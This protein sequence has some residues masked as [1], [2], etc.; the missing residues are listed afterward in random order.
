MS[1]SRQKKSLATQ[2]SVAN[3]LQI[4]NSRALTL[5]LLSG[6]TLTNALMGCSFFQKKQH[7]NQTPTNNT[8]EEFKG[9]IT[10]SSGLPKL[11]PD[12]PSVVYPGGNITPVRVI[13][14]RI[15]IQIQGALTDAQFVATQRESALLSEGEKLKDA[16]LNS[17][18]QQA[19][20]RI[21]D[22]ITIL[23]S[24]ISASVGYFTAWVPY[25]NYAQLQQVTKVPQMLVEPVVVD[26][27]SIQ[28]V[29]DISKSLNDEKLSTDGRGSMDDFSGLRSMGVPEF[30]KQVE[31]E[32]GVKV[33][34]STVK[35]GVGDTGISFNHPAFADEKGNS[36]IIYM[37]DFTGEGT[38]YF[39]RTAAFE[40]KTPTA[41]EVPEGITADEVLILNAEYLETPAGSG[42]RPIADK[43]SK[44]EKTPILVSAQLK[45]ILLTPENGARLGVYNEAL[46]SKKSADEFNDINANGK[47]DDLL[48]AIYVPEKD[49]TKGKIYLDVSGKGDFRKSNAVG[50]WNTT[51]ELVT[52]FSEKFGYDLKATFLLNSANEQVVAMSASVVGFDHGNHGTHVAGIV[53]ARKTLSNDE[54]STL[55]RGA[56][57]NTQIM[58]SRICAVQ[59]GCSATAAA[60]DFAKNGAEVV[61]FSIGGL[62]PEN[63]G[64][65]VGDIITSRLTD[66]Y[67]TLFVIS[68]G[69]SGPGR[70]TIGSPST[71]HKAI[72]VGATANRSMITRQY[73]W[74]GAG[75]SDKNS[76]IEEDFMLFF[77]SRGP[78]ASG[79]FKPNISAPGTELSSIQLNAPAGSRQGLDV[80]WGTS[81]A[82]PAATGAI[83]LL[84]DAAKKYNVIHPTTP[85]PT[86][87]E[88]LRRVVIA[89]ARPFD[90]QSYNTITGEK[91][92]GQYTW[93][94]Q[95]AGMI[96]LPRSW[97]LL[98]D[99][100]SNP[101][102]TSFTVAAAEGNIAVKPEYKVQILRKNPN[103]LDYTGAV[104][105]ELPIGVN[106]NGTK[107][108]VQK[109][110]NGLWLDANTK[111]SL[112]EVH[113]SRSLPESLKSRADVGE[114]MRFL[115]TS[116]DTFELETV[117]HGSKMEWLK[118]GSL[119]TLDCNK[120]SVSPKLTVI[121][122]GG[123][124]TGGGS[125]GF[126]ASNLH[127]CL[128]QSLMAALP[129]GDHGAVINA[130]RVSGGKRETTPSFVV[131]VTMAVPHK[132]LTGLNRYQVQREVKSF[133]VDRNY[134]NIPE[135]TSLV[136]IAL[137]V[138]AT[139]VVGNAVS[140][141]SGAELMILEGQNTAIPAEMS[142]RSKA[143]A[144]NCD[145]K[146]NPIDARR[147]SYE[148]VNPR[149]G[150]WDVHVFGRYQYANSPYTLTVDFAQIMSSLT[151][152]QGDKTALNGEFDITVKE[153]TFKI[154]TSAEKSKYEL[155]GLRQ[156]VTATTEQDKETR[157]ANAAGVVG[158][159]YAAG[160]AAVT[161]STAGATGSDIDLSVLECTE[162][163]LTK[164]DLVGSS[165]GSTD[166]E[167]AQF[168]PKADKFYVG[169]VA[170]YA[171]KGGKSEFKFT[172][173][174]HTEKSDVGT[175]VTT[176]VDETK[177]HVVYSLDADKSTLISSDLFKSGSYDAVGQITM[178]SAEDSQLSVIP[179]VI[180]SKV[181][182]PTPAQ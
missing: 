96:N 88:T 124:T 51:K 77:S 8:Q 61:N 130:Y 83:T 42:A 121:G 176:S 136:R 48:W 65:A 139:S 167:S 85:L 67:N 159:Q 174:I 126:M 97:K 35:M 81:M 144:K 108:I 160:T 99:M 11:T 52:S 26:V 152:I 44:V 72:S 150:T 40:V 5:T 109:F 46:F 15:F 154:S 115:N 91:R 102:N 24:E 128:N 141:C 98:K 180:T 4:G 134:L 39:N 73:Q 13:Q 168:V 133:G 49:G 110:G 38:M 151:S 153:S 10:V 179:V 45:N 101:V 157:V 80:Y 106:A 36:R 69:N 18:I 171:V 19:I 147:V 29:K 94:D 21:S 82:A 87:A 146:G 75:K 25:E 142:P 2:N 122:Q 47:T 50:N 149:V 148:R 111:E 54:D 43:F 104:T 64:Y 71:S 57:P 17:V 118:A 120:G 3:K 28:A 129:A 125:P 92:D 22:S 76:S 74:L 66:L 93:I 78:S 63:D 119:L 138:P 6:L 84:L 9:G 27:N 156:I 127:I 131:P 86:D 169:S 175:L 178:M 1:L 123:S 60:I 116:S 112:I 114:F 95:G 173:L 33:D 31:A 16:R 158:R 14:G 135:G 143:T 70:N 170:G 59:F 79:G 89:G 53:A 20:K 103:G 162:A 41:E 34:G 32:L 56:A 62:S 23:D 37:K 181:P 107:E 163:E 172:E 177:T 90:V 155:T 164:C 105:A 7:Q 55:A 137:E 58:A 100:Q 161:F 145:N 12:L 166:V 140:G 165:G 68:A 113:I 182:A 117:I 132:T 30:Q